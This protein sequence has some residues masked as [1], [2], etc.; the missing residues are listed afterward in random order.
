M[1]F[2]RAAEKN[3]A[4]RARTS[5]SGG[6]AKL[7]TKRFRE[8]LCVLLATLIFELAILWRK[9]H[10]SFTAKFLDLRRN[11]L[12]G[13]KAQARRSSNAFAKDLSNYCRKGSFNLSCSRTRHSAFHCLARLDRCSSRSFSIGCKLNTARNRGWN[14]V[15][16]KSFA[17]FR[18]K[19]GLL[20]TIQLC[21][22]ALVLPSTQRINL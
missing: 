17:G 20:L 22:Q 5:F 10:L 4:S 7:W 6:T 2:T 15:S 1:S 18:W 16:G 13:C 21:P 3:S 12:H 11:V 14:R 8:M 9:I 19:M